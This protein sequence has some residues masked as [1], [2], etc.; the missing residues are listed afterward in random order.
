LDTEIE[1]TLETDSYESDDDRWLDQVAA[2]YDDLRDRGVPLRQESKPA[3]G[4]KG[5]DVAAIIV[6]LGSAGAFTA[7]VAAF[8]EFLGRERTRRLKVRWTVGGQLR[9]VVVTG[10]TDNATLERITREAMEHSSAE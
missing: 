5:G 4:A 9:E 7:A 1:I 10:D 3:P 8:R 6:A 2:F